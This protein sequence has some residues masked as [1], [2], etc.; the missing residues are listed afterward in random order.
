MAMALLL[1]A[2][3]GGGGSPVTTGTSPESRPDKLPVTP[4]ETPTEVA[5]EKPPD[6]PSDDPSD[7]AQANQKPEQP[8]TKTDPPETDM[9]SDDLSDV[10]QDNERETENTNKGSADNNSDNPTDGRSGTPL[11]APTNTARPDTDEIEQTQKEEDMSAHTQPRPKQRDENDPSLLS[12]HFDPNMPFDADPRRPSTIPQ[13]QFNSDEGLPPRMNPPA[14]QNTAGNPAGENPAGEN[15]AGENSRNDS[16]DDDLPSETG[17][18]A[19]E[20]PWRSPS[21]EEEN[22]SWT[23][24][25][26]DDTFADPIPRFPTSQQQPD[27]RTTIRIE[28]GK[29]DLFALVVE[30]GR[31]MP[32]IVA[33]ELDVPGA[34]FEGPD[35]DSFHLVHEPANQPEGSP[36]RLVI[37]FSQPPDQERPGDD[38]G[39]NSYEFSLG[40]LLSSYWGDLTFKV[41]VVDAPDPIGERPDPF[42][43]VPD[44]FEPFSDPIVDLPEF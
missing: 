44:P 43:D 9:S 21:A 14:P 6:I 37:R 22:R 5:L 16:P 41:T 42:V 4:P 15:P 19:P 17:V 25:P 30:D 8:D 31:S 11:K 26:S 13:D 40:R 7:E 39:D 38:D 1:S 3:G 20:F 28:E 24:I 33:P 32:A 27:N 12:P 10:K 18:L 29:I 23:N 35:G 2:C 36:E 34:F